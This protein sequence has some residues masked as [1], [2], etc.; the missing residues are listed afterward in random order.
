[1]SKTIGISDRM[2]KIV[3]FVAHQAGCTE[4]EAIL[5]IFAIAETVYMVTTDSSVKISDSRETTII[6]GLRKDGN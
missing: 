3:H 4:D 1:M 6:E 5:R 2:V